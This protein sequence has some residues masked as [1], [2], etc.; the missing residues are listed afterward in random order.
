MDDRP[1]NVNVEFPKRF[2]W[3]MLLLPLFIWGNSLLIYFHQY[4]LRVSVSSMEHQL[5]GYFHINALTFSTMAAMFYYAAMIMQIPSG[6]LIDRYG[7]R[8][9]LTCSALILSLGCFFFYQA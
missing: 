8:N 5:L 4:F 1:M 9:M 2:K 6:L 3:L 7:V